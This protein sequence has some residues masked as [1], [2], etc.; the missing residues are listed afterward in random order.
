M[1]NSLGLTPFGKYWNLWNGQILQAFSWLGQM[2]EK[3]HY[4]FYFSMNLNK[5]LCFIYIKKINSTKCL[6]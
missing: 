6:F 3:I 1:Q 2:V 4:N 5:I